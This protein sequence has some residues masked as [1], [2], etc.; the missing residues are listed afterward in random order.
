MTFKTRILKIWKDPLHPAWIVLAMVELFVLVLC[1]DRFVLEPRSMQAAI[2]R[3]N[4][5]YRIS[6]FEHA[7]LLLG[8]PFTGA[9]AVRAGE[10]INVFAGKPTAGIAGGELWLI[11][12]SLV[13]AYVAGPSLLYHGLK[14]WKARK[15]GESPRRSSYLPLIASATGGYVV[16]VALMYPAF[17]APES[18]MMLQ[19]MKAD[20][21]S[22]TVRDDAANS[23][24]VLAFRAQQLRMMPEAPGGGPWVQGP[25]G[26]T[27]AD[28]RTALHGLERVLEQPD[29]NVS[30]RYV[31]EVESQDSL[32]IWGVAN[33]RGGYAI[34]GAAR[35]TNIDS[36]T[37]NVQVYAG[38]TPAR[39][40]V[41]VDN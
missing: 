23:V 32:T 38:V 37:G 41:G 9:A 17:S 14:A 27:I 8:S 19:Q 2:G 13:L 1:F 40:R 7:N 11:G 15:A 6:Y 30:I 33:A 29:A 22:N 34:S 4:P 16:C 25:G 35:F 10:G 12:I 21:Y 18:W 3:G 28:L 20:S 24:M 31:L 36:T 39:M 5:Y 26:I